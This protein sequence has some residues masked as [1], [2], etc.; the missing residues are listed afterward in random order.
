MYDP[1]L[2]AELRAEFAAVRRRLLA[3]LDGGARVS[4]AAAYLYEDLDRK[5]GELVDQLAVMS[6]EPRATTA[7]RVVEGRRL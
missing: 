1:A 3:A 6:G 4:V 5:T 7:P 2:I